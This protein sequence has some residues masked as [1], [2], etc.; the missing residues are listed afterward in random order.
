M[1]ISI[2]IPVFNE[3]FYTKKCIESIR[4]NSE[5][6]QYEIIVIDNASDDGTQDFLKKENIIYIY[7]NENIGVAKA[8]NQGIKNS[9]GDFVCIINNDI[10]VCKDWLFN[11]IK[12]YE[13][14]ENTGI[15][16]PATREGQLNY[17]FEK[18]SEKFIKKM[19]NIKE[20]GFFGWCMFIKKD[21][22]EKIGLFSE[23]YETGIGEDTDFYLRLK[24]QN[25]ESYITGSVFVHHFGSRTL[26]KVKEKKGDK[27]EKEN[28]LKLR[29][30]WGIK[31]DNYLTRKTKNFFKFLK[32][33]YLKIFYGFTLIE[34]K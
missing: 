31:E 20:K 12:F 9:K 10:I 8:W 7:N 2:I 17:D 34:K 3:L 23:E 14:K 33:L 30:K 22:F 26:I 13:T 18:Y 21:K 5:N 28:I 27:F 4:K 1:K 32:K 24:K 25:F 16:S 15:L 6:I 19:K 29:I 11:F